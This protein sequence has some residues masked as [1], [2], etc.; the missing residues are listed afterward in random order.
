MAVAR[1][2]KALAR[3]SNHGL[4]HQPNCFLERIR[5]KAT[6]KGA[7]DAVCVSKTETAPVTGGAL[8]ASLDIQRSPFQS[9]SNARPR[10]ASLVA[11]ARTD[12][13]AVLHSR[14]IQNIKDCLKGD[15]ALP[16]C[17]RC[18]GGVD[19][20]A[21]PCSTTAMCSFSLYGASVIMKLYAISCRS[22]TR[23]HMAPVQ[24]A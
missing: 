21:V 1:A 14:A 15:K 24:H 13:A 23:A 9:A 2:F 10:H 5:L 17:V 19:C 6:A 12:I 11:G 22:C 3:G 7:S 8:A 20:S 4:R 18:V 16:D